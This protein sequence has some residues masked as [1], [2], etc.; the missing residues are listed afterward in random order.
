MRIGLVPSLSRPG[1]NI[2]S[3]TQLNL[4]IMPKRLE[5]IHELLP[6]ATDFALLVNPA[7]SALAESAA[8]S[9]QAA[10]QSLGLRLHVVH[11]RSDADFDAAFAQL[12]KLHVAGLVIA[13]DAFFFSRRVQLAKQ[14]I[15]HAMPAVLE[16]HEFVASGGLASYGG[17]FK[18]S[19]RLAG[20]YVARILKGERPGELPVQQATK[21]ELLLNVKIAKAL[22]LAIPISVLGR[23][24]EVIE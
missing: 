16:T 12:S 7:S 23:A 15:R 6:A 20:A 24:D 10:A 11:A 2:T 9:S 13:P 1:G 18:E 3:V 21:V 4:E 17:S 19:Y 14:S 22:G 5:L 8:R